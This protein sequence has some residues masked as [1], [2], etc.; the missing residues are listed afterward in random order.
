[1]NHHLAVAEAFCQELRQTQ[2]DIVAILLAGSVARQQTASFSDIDLMVIVADGE[3]KQRDRSASTWYDGIYIDIGLLPQ[4]AFADL[5]QILG[6]PSA[7]ASLAYG[8]ILHDPSGFLATLQAQVRAEYRHPR[9]LQ[10]RGDAI[11]SRLEARFDKLRAAVAQQDALQVCIHAGQ[12]LFGIA[13]LPLIRQGIA[14]SSTR[15]LMQ[16]AESAPEVAQ[17]ICALE[18]SRAMTSADFATASHLFAQLTLLGD[19]SRWGQ[20]PIYMMRKVEWMIHHDLE[21]AALHTMWNNVGFRINDCLAT[22]GV[23]DET[24][25]LAQAWLRQTGWTDEQTFAAKLEMMGE[26][27]ERV[28]TI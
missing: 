20:L 25:P 12:I 7:A 18:G 9:W 27:F 22:P 1:M 8:K 24:L 5:E 11:A 26:L 19:T 28:N 4:S 2:P 21:A 3:G 16:L 17:S 13:L 23:A 6:N 15:H 14:P 10:V